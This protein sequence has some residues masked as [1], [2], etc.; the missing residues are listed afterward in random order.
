MVNQDIG[1]LA[2]RIVERGVEVLQVPRSPV[3]VFGSARR[4]DM[5]SQIRLTKLFRS[6]IP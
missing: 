2:V 3:L 1:G 6:S 5:M 4:Q